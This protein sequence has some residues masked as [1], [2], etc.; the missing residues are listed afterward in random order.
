[1]HCSSLHIQCVFCGCNRERYIKNLYKW[2][3]SVYT[4]Y[5]TAPKQMTK[6]MSENPS[7]YKEQS[8]FS[9]DQNTGVQKCNKKK[10]AL[11]STYDCR[12]ILFDIN[13][14][15]YANLGNFR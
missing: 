12:F 5:N 2:C 10:H 9:A 4:D 7:V 8:M 6:R 13:H 14:I 11:R 1:M 15:A 3:H